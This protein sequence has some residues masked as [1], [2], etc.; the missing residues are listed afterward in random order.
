MPL[1][2]LEQVLH[3][4]IDMINFII[5][6][7]TSMYVFSTGF[8]VTFFEVIKK[9]YITKEDFIIGVSFLILGSYGVF[10]SLKYIL[11]VGWL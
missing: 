8:Y 1:H 9:G 11:Q 4:M 7:L 6:Y 2:Q 3:A 5:L 10:I